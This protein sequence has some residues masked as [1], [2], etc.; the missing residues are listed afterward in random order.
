MNILQR[1]NPA[2]PPESL[3]GKDVFVL[4]RER[5]LQYGLIGVSAIATILVPMVI[6]R[7][8]AAKNWAL[9]I[10]YSLAYFVALSITYF[11][12]IP[13]SV[14]SNIFTGLFFL[15]GVVDLMG[16]GMSGEGRLF[17]M[18]FVVMTAILSVER[19]VFRSILTGVTS[20]I[21]LTI[22]GWGMSSGWITAPPVEALTNSYRFGD[23][24]NGNVVFLMTT[25]AV[26][27]S[28]L[29]LIAR[30]QQAL[31]NQEKSTEE[32]AVERQKLQ[33]DFD[34]QKLEVNR[35]ATQLETAS[36]LARDISKFT[37]LDT[38]LSSAVNLIRD[39]FGYY[40]AGLFLL[41]G[42]KEYAVLR[43]A[44]GDAGRQMLANNHRLRVGEVGLVGYA[45]SKG[46]SR[47]AQNVYQDTFHFKNPI[48]P[49]TRSELA[50]PLRVG[51]DIIGALDVQ[52]EKEMAFEQEDV[53]ILQLIADQLAV[54]INK[55][56]I[57]D[58]LQKTVDDLKERYL[59][60]TTSSWN[61]FLTKETK[62]VSMS[63]DRTTQELTE[64]PP[65][66]AEEQKA[67]TEKKTILASKEADSEQKRTQ[68][69]VPLMLRDNLVLGAMRIEFDG[70]NIP[71]QTV[72]ML[73]NLSN[74]LALALDR[75]RLMNEIQSTAE[76]DRLITDV[77]SK[78]R[79]SSNIDNILKTAASEIGRS[80]GASEVIVQLLP[81]T[82]N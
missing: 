46:E 28:L 81:T 29:L 70:E 44:T 23:W 49:D 80:L 40:H 36:A 37:N 67:I 16:S 82:D 48:L 68:I 47:I 4:L 14:R 10:V 51:G 32:L 9:V 65:M 62:T 55:A 60:T 1:I 76:Q 58:Q 41:D 61:Q 59:Q 74:R 6:I 34:Q 45:V 21:L 18:A 79:S 20:V 26:I 75:A 57:L 3:A 54:A 5:I 33:A 13:Y 50:L 73:E 11:R 17:L 56:Q 24:I 63:L 30:A 78:I 12:N 15:I 2:T 35:R 52:S 7:D 64:S 25:T 77:S 66:T 53:K 8:I 22:V 42:N 31:R 19:S 72:E 43:S 27:S 39:Q 71:K 38:L 69:S